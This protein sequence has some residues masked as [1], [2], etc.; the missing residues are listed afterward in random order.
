MK[1]DDALLCQA[2]FR[3]NKHTIWGQKLN[4]GLQIEYWQ[5]A[6]IL[7]V[8]SYIFQI[9][10]ASHSLKPI[11][12]N[13]SAFVLHNWSS[14]VLYL[15][16]FMFVFHT[17]LNSSGSATIFSSLMWNSHKH[18]SLKRKWACLVGENLKC[19]I[20]VSNLLQLAPDACFDWLSVF[21][22][23]FSAMAQRQ[24]LDLDADRKQDTL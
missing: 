24:P 7:Y 16:K 19:Q 17:Y 1:E 12:V 9:S 10:T 18:S 11:S 21:A 4:L 23:Y 6:K 8:Y 14:A 3:P 2:F 20:N 13:S 15:F 5:L 22:M